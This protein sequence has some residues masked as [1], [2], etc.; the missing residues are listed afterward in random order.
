MHNGLG[1]VTTEPKQQSNQGI[2]LL[3]MCAGSTR[4]LRVFNKTFKAFVPT[5][6]VKVNT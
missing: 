5:S 3:D 6:Q 2:A 4:T 1:L